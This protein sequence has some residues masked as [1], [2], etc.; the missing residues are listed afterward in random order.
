MALIKTPEQVEKLRS[1]GALLSRC[2]DMLVTNAKPGV[3]GKQLDSLAEEFIKDHHAIP[4]FKDYAIRPDLPKFPASICFSRNHV[5]VHGIP[6]ENDVIEEG[7][8]ITIDSG[9]SLEGWFAD[10]ARLFGV[11]EISEEDAEIIKASKEAI[12]AGINQCHVGVRI[13]A[14]GNAIENNIAFSK[15]RNIIE[16][17]GHFIGEA[18]HEPPQIPNF[19][20]KNKGFRLQPGMVFCL[21]PMLKKSKIEIAILPDKWTVVTLDKSRATHIEHMVLITDGGPEILTAFL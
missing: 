3:S 17:C 10:A 16:F 15:F 13:G 1:S 8:I 2:L 4:A 19:G 20:Q 5:V 9:L 21:E 6:H 7:D 12:M 18:M 14:V 11:G